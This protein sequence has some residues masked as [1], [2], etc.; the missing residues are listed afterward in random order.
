MIISRQVL[1]VCEDCDED[2]ETLQEALTEAGKAVELFRTTSGD[3]C[4]RLLRSSNSLV[5]RATL[6]L[7]DLN[8]PGSDRLDA[9]S[10][11]KLDWQLQRLPVVI[12]SASSNPVDLEFCYHNNAN[13]Y[14]IKPTAYLEHIE[15][16]KDILGY[17][18]GKV[19]LLDYNRKFIG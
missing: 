13:A 17:W 4:L 12:F 11:I 3:E 9:L 14:H 18:L 7:I 19:S 16:L 1:V 8:T 15:V 10:E 2:F 6:V 5:T